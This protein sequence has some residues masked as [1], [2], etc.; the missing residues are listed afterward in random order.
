MIRAARLDEGGIFQGVDELEDESKLTALHLR[1]IDA[2]DLEPGKYKWLSDDTNPMGGAFWPMS[3]LA[4]REKLVADVEEEQKRSEFLA[5]AR[6][7]GITRRQA[8][9]NWRRFKRD[10]ASKEE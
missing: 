1:Q 3:F 2:C 8:I 6:K 4:L 7:S 10:Q 5:E 9:M